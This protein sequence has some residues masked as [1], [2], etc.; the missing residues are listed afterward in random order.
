ML[1]GIAP[2]F[3]FL[4]QP[5]KHQAFRSGL[6]SSRKCYWQ[7]NHPRVCSDRIADYIALVLS[8]WS[9]WSLWL[10]RWSY[11]WSH[12]FD[13]FD[14]SNRI[15]GRI[16]D[17]I[18]LIALFALTVSL[19]VLLIV[20]L[21]SLCSEVFSAFSI[22]LHLSTP[23]SPGG[24]RRDLPPWWIRTYIWPFIKIHLRTLDRWII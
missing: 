21:W 2:L 6:W 12:R 10:Y 9:L 5:P 13:H 15:A 1:S 11:R 8:L 17:R 20:S 22:I 14:C 23:Q 16:V 18:A 4:H 3:I 7:C 24:P 19:V